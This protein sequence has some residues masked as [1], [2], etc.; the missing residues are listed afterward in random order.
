MNKNAL[1]HLVRLLTTVLLLTLV[2]CNPTSETIN[3]PS[4]APEQN[5]DVPADV[6][7]FED[8]QDSGEGSEGEEQLGN[9]ETGELLNCPPAGQL[10]YLGL[11]HAVTINY[12]EMSL[13]HFLHQGMV[14]LDTLEGG[15]I[16]TSIP[17]NLKYSMEGV[18]SSECSISGEGQMTVTVQGT[19]ED[20]VVK[21]K[22]DE[23]WQAASGQMECIDEDGDVTVAPFDVPAAGSMPNHGPDGEGEV[24]LLTD[25]ES[26]YVVM[27]PFEQGQ[28][29]HTWTLYSSLVPT[30]PLV[31]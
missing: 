13:S 4:S 24:F 5:G 23:N 31:P 28:G 30:V 9:Q 11:D 17:G 18:M 19:C 26:G 22:I 1:T 27:R 7:D 10:L 12:G 6:S 21:L 8:G 3:P 15:Q 14:Y 29:Y 2:S 25:A 16:G 20:G